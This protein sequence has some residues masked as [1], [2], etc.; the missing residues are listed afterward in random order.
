MLED[1]AGDEGF[2]DARVFVRLE[3]LQRILGHA[4]VLCSFCAQFTAL[5]NQVLDP[6]KES[7]VRERLVPL[8]GGMVGVVAGSGSDIW[9]LV[10][11]TIYM[12]SIVAMWLLRG[13]RAGNCAAG[14]VLL[15]WDG[16]ASNFERHGSVG[17][18]DLLLGARGPK[19]SKSSSL[20]SSP[21]HM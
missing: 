16:M 17:S 11:R 3:M 15:M 21:S 10:G 14:A 20:G 5:A 6:Q 13:V 4:F 12:C 1:V 8:L 18:V 2:I 7:R 19:R 9:V